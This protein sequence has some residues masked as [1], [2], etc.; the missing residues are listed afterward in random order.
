MAV[1]SA[2]AR[3]LL[4]AARLCWYVRGIAA[5]WPVSPCVSSTTSWHWKFPFG[6]S[7][8]VAPWPWH[9]LS[10]RSPLAVSWPQSFLPVGLLMVVPSCRAFSRLCLAFARR[11]LFA[12]SRSCSHCLF[13]PVTGLWKRLGAVVLM[14]ALIWTLVAVGAWCG[15]VKVRPVSA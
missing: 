8:V 1:F 7:L 3:S 12:S 15:V 9:F 4:G 2:L 11:R 6:N 5:Q 14:C 10:G 13:S